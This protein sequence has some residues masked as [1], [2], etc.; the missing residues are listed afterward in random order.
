VILF[1]HFQTLEKIMIGKIINDRYRL[2]AVL[3]HGGMGAVYRAHDLELERD[4][5]IKL[6]NQ[7][8]F[9]NNERDRLLH[10]AKVIAKIRHP[11]IVS[12]YDVGESEDAPFFVMEYVEGGS[13]RENHP[14]DL[15][16]ILGIIIQ[17]CRGLDGAHDKGIIHRDLKP[18]NVL[19]EKDRTVKL[20]DFGIARSDITRFTSE[21]QITGTANYLAPET[22]KGEDIDG[23]ADL[24]SLGVIMYELTTGQLP[25]EADSLLGLINKHLFEEAVPPIEF[26]PHLPLELNELILRMLSKDPEGRPA[27]ARKVGQ[28][29]ETSGDIF[30]HTAKTT[31]QTP[32][33]TPVSNHN[34][35][36]Q[37]SSFIG[38]QADLIQIGE[39]LADANCRLLTLVGIGGIGKTRLAIQAAYEALEKYADGVWMVELASLTEADLLPQKVGSLF[40]VSA[41]EAREGVGETDVLVDYLQEKSLLLVID[42]CEHLIEACATFSETLLKG[43]SNVKL[44]ATS[45]EDLRIPGEK[46]FFVSPLHLPP[47]H[48][49][50][51]NLDT[52]ESIQLYIERAGATQPEFLLTP[53]NENAVLQICNQLDGIPLAIEL[54]AAKIKVLTPHQV[55]ERLEDRFQLLTSGSRTALPRHQTLEAAIDWSYD[56][57]SREE[58]ILLRRLA[59]FSGGWTLEAAEE[60]AKFGEEDN[61]VI[62]GLLSQLVDKSLVLVDEKEH[63]KR[64][65]LLET[66]RQ[67]GIN[68]LRIKEELES[69]RQSHLDYFVKLAEETDEG[70]RD[71]RQI[72]S[73]DVLDIEHDNFR[74]A[75]RHSI[76]KADPDFAFRLVGALGWFWFMRGYWKDSW[77]WL[78]QSL[79]L[80]TDADPI[81]RAK[82]IYRAGG[83]ELIRGKLAGT[84]ELVEEALQICYEE[85]DKEG[86]AWC[87]NLL[88]QAGTFGHKDT[89]TAI[90]NL[91]ESI[92][93]FAQFENDW[94]AAWSLRYL[95]QVAEIQG[96]YKRSIESQKDALHRFEE[97]G[98]IWNSAHSFYLMGNSIYQHGDFQEARWAYEQSLEKCKL[99]ED[100]V[101][102]AH[103]LRGLALLAIQRDDL[104]QAKQLSLDALESLQKIGD[105]NCASAALRDLGE[106]A[107]RRGEFERSAEL[108]NQSLLSFAE[109][110]NEVPIGITVERFA[111][112]AGSIGNDAKAAQLLAAVDEHIGDKINS[113]PTLQ[114]EHKKLVSSTQE[115]LGQQ[116]FEQLWAEGAEM[117]LEQAIAYAIEE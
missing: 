51:D 107:R 16:G 116:V 24:Y 67:Y 8:V 82:A 11:N 110:G 52:Y 12:I 108:L 20:V 109:M 2:D 31:A 102:A 113:S 61:I 79:D 29:L 103:A 45:R 115:H 9:M 72:E 81:L 37:P 65:R 40:G 60:V 88:G 80:S 104:D 91:S 17:I 63:T 33:P 68:K 86:Q 26:A 27:S 90:T 93:I 39:M 76:D 54:A 75:L 64:Y 18:E 85:N 114:R 35:Q 36:T 13:L 38:R 46:L 42:N 106:I 3:G 101:M 70:L 89:E 53:E 49:P 10:E 34:L 87:L 55:A 22:I 25:F 71:D 83:L 43:C 4:V 47:E 56:L 5:A 111:A 14:G 98:D 30:D 84:I 100:K 105:E 97:I 1:A 95:G 57:L 66:V 62:L 117:S 7:V 58:Q 92:E 21:E 32:I 74:R 69:A 77:K 50:V 48:T 41:Q 78:N 23:R 96:D 112:L 28:I 15:D 6:L 44:L 19:L 73:L 59:V 94:G 99:V